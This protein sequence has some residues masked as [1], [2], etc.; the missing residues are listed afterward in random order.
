MKPT[1][2]RDSINQFGQNVPIVLFEDCRAGVVAQGVDKERDPN[3]PTNNQMLS[4]DP[5]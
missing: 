3:S 2:Y 4:S 1:I 5:N